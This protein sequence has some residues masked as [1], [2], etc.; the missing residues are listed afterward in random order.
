MGEPG[1]LLPPKTWGPVRVGEAAFPGWTA[2][3]LPGGFADVF[4]ARLEDPW[5]LPPGLQALR[6]RALFSRIRAVRPTAALWVAVEA[7]GVWL[8]EEIARG[9]AGIPAPVAVTDGR[10]PS[11][12]DFSFSPR[13]FPVLSPPPLADPPPAF[14]KETAR[15]LLVLLRLREAA[16]AEVAAQ[17]GLS[18]SRARE[19]L[20]GLAAAGRAVEA[21]S[22]YPLWRLARPGLSAA[23]RMLLLPPGARF[24]DGREKG[25][26]GRHRRAARLWPAWVRKALGAE[27]WGGWS[28]AVLSGDLRPDGLAWGR[29][30]GQETLFLLEAESGHRAREDL[31][32]RLRARVGRIAARLR[33]F[34]VVLTVLGPPWVLRT[35]AADPPELPGWIAVVLE[36]WKAFG[37]LPEPAFGRIMIAP[38]MIAG[39]PRL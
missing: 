1:D 26:R 34:P 31:R 2:L 13:L 14:P 3:P 35:L 22:P 19:I 37:R 21:G 33:G 32:R 38:E 20:R 4:V 7:P 24:F 9:L 27:I 18:P 11:R 23:R 17:A 16:T 30:K 39:G 36:D 29:W 28:E 15:T 12:E 25:G 10:P 5:G 8:R 6:I